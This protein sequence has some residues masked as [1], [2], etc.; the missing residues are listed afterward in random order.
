M[1]SATHYNVMPPLDWL[2]DE[3]SNLIR[4]EVVHGRFEL[5]QN[6]VLRE[7]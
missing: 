2:P 3:C 7:I 4:A 1:T 5:R 6:L